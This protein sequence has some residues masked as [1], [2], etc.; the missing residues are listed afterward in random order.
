[1]YASREMW[2]GTGM[3]VVAE[4]YREGSPAG[5]EASSPGVYWARVSL[6]AATVLVTFLSTLGL[7]KLALALGVSPE[8][9]H[10]SSARITPVSVALILSFYALQI[11]L[12]CCVH[13]FVHR[14]RLERLRFSS[15][16]W[17]ELG[18]GFLLGAAVGALEKVSDVL[19]GTGAT[20][21]WAVPADVS[22]AS[23]LAHYLLWFV[24]ILTLNSLNEELT[25]RV[26]PLEHLVDRQH[27]PAL[28]VALTAL[29]FALIHHM[30]EPFA[31]TAFATRFFAGLIFGL[32]YLRFRS[33]WLVCGLHNG[34]N[35]SLLSV[36]GSWQMG[37]LWEFSAQPGPEWLRAL[38]RCLVLAAALA[39]I[40]RYSRGALTPPAGAP[41]GVSSEAG[42]MTEVRS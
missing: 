1:M 36:S 38:T 2:E 6:V 12:V 4:A 18:V 41:V 16:F 31:W 35:F 17:P 30:F 3:R 20:L 27:Q 28:V 40:E 9:L 39:L 5:E 14:Q 19:V 23:V 22:A 34:M 37:G 32:A 13:R 11:G 29:A 8:D 10:G 33:L 42:G 15:R 21:R 25:F 7:M 26:Y 24:V